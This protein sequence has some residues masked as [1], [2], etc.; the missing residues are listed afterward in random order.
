MKD[1]ESADVG[2]CKKRIVLN[3]GQKS[4]NA[5]ISK[6]GTQ[7]S[8]PLVSKLCVSGGRVVIEIQRNARAR[9]LVW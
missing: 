5:Y 8:I 7:K 4:R 3:L 6:T 2:S 1:N 9:S